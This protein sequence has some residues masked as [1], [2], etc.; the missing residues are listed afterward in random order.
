MKNPHP[1]VPLTK[2]Q[3]NVLTGLMLG[4]GHLRI[5]KSN[6]NAALMVGRS[7]KDFPYMEYELSLF[8]NFCSPLTQ[9]RGPRVIDKFDKIISSIRKECAFNTV[10]SPSFTPYHKLWYPNGKKKI[11]PNDLILSPQIIA[12]WIC[13]DGH[14]TY[15]KLPYRLKLELSTHGFS[16]EEVNFLSKLLEN[17]YNEKFLVKK[18]TRK[19]KVYFMIKAYDSACRA[20]F[21]DIDSFFKM[22]RKRIWDKPESRFYNDVP[23][24]QT[25]HIESLKE[26]KEIL[27][28]IVKSSSSSSSSILLKDLAVELSYIYNGVIDYKCI[29]KLL[30]PYIADGIIIKEI[31]I[32]N[33][34][35]CKLIIRK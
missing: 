23:E 32:L 16:E 20:L 19:D 17:K 11:V 34:N 7:Y 29:N 31:D 4:D 13:D 9:N 14:V 27:D 2:E 1:Y 18:K 30:K 3:H 28:N 5:A 25:S 22:D 35:T 24:R 15:N 21:K 10:A 12:H 8:Y 26:R 6:I 33:N